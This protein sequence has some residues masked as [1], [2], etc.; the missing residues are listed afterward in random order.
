[1]YTTCNLVKRSSQMEPVTLK[2]N[3]DITGQRLLG[4]IPEGI[5]CR[6]DAAREALNKSK[7]KWGKQHWQYVV[8][9]LLT[10]WHIVSTA[11]NNEVMAQLAPKWELDS[12]FY[13]LDI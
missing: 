3:T 6:L 2:N 5:G 7:T 4:D 9:H 10:Q 8:N 1:M 13:K 11:P 12:G